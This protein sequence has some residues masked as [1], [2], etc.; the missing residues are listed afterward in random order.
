VSEAGRWDKIWSERPREAHVWYS[1]QAPPELRRLLSDAE[2]PE[3]GALDVG[4]G[5]GASTAFLSA[6]FQPAVGLDVA[7]EALRQ[8]RQ[9]AH[10]KQANCS[11]VLAAAP[12][13]PFRDGA[14]AF[15]FDRGCI[16]NLPRPA[17]PGYFREIDRLLRPGGLFELY[18]SGALPHRSAARAVRLRIERALHKRKPKRLTASLLTTLLPSSMEILRVE[19]PSSD[20]S[21]GRTL[22]FTHCVFRKRA[23]V[24]G[25]EISPRHM[26]TGGV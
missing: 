25:D 10:G 20:G 17:W 9:F 15:V 13:L 14:F 8:A 12:G 7:M 4:C 21:A 1:T 24:E 5:A 19:N 18:F 2:F 23:L 26:D 6:R 11:F 16:H 3:G 22:R